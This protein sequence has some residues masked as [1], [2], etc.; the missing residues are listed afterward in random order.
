MVS[1]KKTWVSGTLFWLNR[2]HDEVFEK[3]S[4]TTAAAL[5]KSRM[6]DKYN[7]RQK[8]V[9]SRSYIE[10]G[11]TSS[12]KYQAYA[13][14]YPAYGKGIWWLTRLRVNAF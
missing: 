14:K 10:W 7:D 11:L 12:A 5:V 8:G 3:T 2:F 9:A 6:L 4:P 1:R 13:F